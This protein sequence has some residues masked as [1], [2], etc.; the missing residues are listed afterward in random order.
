MRKNHSNFLST[1]FLVEI[2]SS[3][4]REKTAMITIAPPNKLIIVG[5][6]LKNNQT[7]IGAK[8]NSKR[9]NKVISAAN[10]Y[11]AE[12][13]KREKPNPWITTPHIRDKTIS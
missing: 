6:S 7:Q 13:I 3:A 11:R 1:I 4:A 8:E 10:K 2:N 9:L 12:I 5:S